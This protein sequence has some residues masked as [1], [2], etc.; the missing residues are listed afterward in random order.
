MSSL[1]GCPSHLPGP[2]SSC[3]MAESELGTS[4]RSRLVS[5]WKCCKAFKRSQNEGSRGWSQLNSTCKS[6]SLDGSLALLRI[7]QQM[8]EGMWR[9]QRLGRKCWFCDWLGWVQG[10][11]TLPVMRTILMPLCFIK[12]QRSA[13]H[14]ISPSS[15]ISSKRDMLSCQSRVNQWE[16]FNDTIK[17]A[18]LLM[19]DCL[20]MPSVVLTRPEVKAWSDDNTRDESVWEP[21][22]IPLCKG[23]EGGRWLAHPKPEM[24]SHASGKTQNKSCILMSSGIIGSRSGYKR[25]QWKLQRLDVLEE[26]RR[27]CVTNPIA[28]WASCESC[29]IKK[30][31]SLGGRNI[32][33]IDQSP[34]DAHLLKSYTSMHLPLSLVSFNARPHQWKY[35]GSSKWQRNLEVSAN[36]LRSWWSM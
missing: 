32:G 34:R 25:L 30:Y 9:L 18:R 22:V 26:L 20:S 3:G 21:Y 1:T 11:D 24:W 6:W 31:I 7:A 29:R 35:S 5:F 10:D 19:G 36:A 17:I 2:A 14:G 16:G 27:K 28:L 33:T 15:S 23:I 13:N 8:A 4:W 12:K